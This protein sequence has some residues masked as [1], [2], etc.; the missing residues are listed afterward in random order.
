MAY[1]YAFILY[2]R[3]AQGIF[4]AIGLALAAYGMKVSESQ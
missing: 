1:T 3:I 4:A 2:L